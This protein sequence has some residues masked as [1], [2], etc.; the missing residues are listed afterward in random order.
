MEIRM[1]RFLSLFSVLIVAT[2]LQLHPLSAQATESK[3]RLWGAAGAHIHSGG[4]GPTTQ[5]TLR[6][7]LLEYLVMDATGRSGTVLINR[8]GQDPYFAALLIGA[9]V[10]T[11]R[12]LH[13]WELR[14]TPRFMHVHHAPGQSWLDTPGAN[15]SGDSSGSVVHRSG[16]ELAMGVTFPATGAIGPYRLLWS[17]ELNAGLLPSSEEMAR[18]IGFLIALSLARRD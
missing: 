10:S 14:L 13:N 1:A 3:L 9:G 16:A 5:L 17:A 18:S 12:L 11:G 2:T 4:S 8:D 7:Q 6:Y 15:L